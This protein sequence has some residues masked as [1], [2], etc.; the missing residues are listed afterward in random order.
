MVRD[1]CQLH[2]FAGR[3]DE[4]ERNFVATELSLGATGEMLS[5]DDRAT[6]VYRRA[7]IIGGRLDRTL[8]I[9]A[10]RLP[11]REWLVGLFAQDQI[12]ELDR[13]AL[14]TGRPLAP[15]AD[16]GPMVCACLKVGARAIEAACVAGAA[17]VE[18][19]GAATG[20]GTNCGSCKIEIARMI[21][22]KDM[23]NAA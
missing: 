4:V 16:V 23:V 20:A 18:A 12:S 13:V 1:S 9:G 6:G 2:E 15:I 22:N 11:P 10:G 3:G 21:A 19:V 14:L 7:W 5:F 17:T 8:F